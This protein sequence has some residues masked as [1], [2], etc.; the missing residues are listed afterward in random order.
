MTV[1]TILAGTFLFLCLRFVARLRF[2]TTGLVVSSTV[3]IGGLLFYALKIIAGFRA[4]DD[5]CS[6]CKTKGLHCG[7]CVKDWS[8]STQIRTQALFAAV[9]GV[10]AGAPLE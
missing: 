4:M 2:D 7:G 5:P 10:E 6:W 1:V 8:D 9:G 3:P